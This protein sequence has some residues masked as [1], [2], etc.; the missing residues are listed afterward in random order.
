MSQTQ[1]WRHYLLKIMS[2]TKLQFGIIVLIAAGAA[3]ALVVQHEIQARLCAENESL[4][5]QLAQPKPANEEA[6]LPAASG[7]NSNSLPDK[8]FKEL[9]RLRSEV[10][11][12]RRQ[13]NELVNWLA[14]TQNSQP[15]QSRD[16]TPA[17]GQQAPPALPEE[18]PKTADGAAKGILDTFFRGDWDT[19]FANFGQPGVPRETYDQMFRNPRVS[20]YLASIETMSFGEP[21]NSFSRNKWAVPYKMRFKDGSE[22]EW[23]LY[24][25]RDPKT[26][27]WYFDGGF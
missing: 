14:K 10:G 9:L 23:Q 18:Y 22:K 3:T 16:A 17:A 5:L 24:V 1:A 7:E 2:R 25:G 11:A 26:Q 8:E 20:N 4:R 13:T 27:R 12:L 6:A 15:T 21:T 19:F